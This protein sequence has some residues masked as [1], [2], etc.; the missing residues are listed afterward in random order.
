MHP[1][2]PDSLIQLLLKRLERVSADSYWAHRASGVRGSL[3]RSLEME[4]QGDAIDQ[5]ELDLSLNDAFEILKHAAAG[6]RR[7]FD[8]Q[9]QTSEGSSEQHLSAC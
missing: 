1:L 6:P 9:A 4:E 5:R 3:L 2:E 8:P 7:R